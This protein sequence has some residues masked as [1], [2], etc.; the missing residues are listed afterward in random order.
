MHLS[1]VTQVFSNKGCMTYFLQIMLIS[2]WGV[3]YVT[4]IF[5]VYYYMSLC[6]T[7]FLTSLK[8]KHRLLQIFCGCFWDRPLLS[9]FKSGCYPFFY[10]FLGNFVQLLVNFKNSSSLRPL[11]RNHPYIWF[12]KASEELISSLFCDYIYTF[13]KPSLFNPF[14]IIS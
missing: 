10:G 14:L 8:P 13:N 7:P 1:K 11:T 9:L 4:C 3:T 2:F 12:G 5:T 6:N